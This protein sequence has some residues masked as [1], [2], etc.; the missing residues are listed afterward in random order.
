MSSI[1][2][3][4]GPS[5]APLLFFT[6]QQG[7]QV[8][9]YYDHQP[10]AETVVLI[11]IGRIETALKYL[12]IAR[13]LKQFNFDVVICEHRGQGFSERLTRNPHIGDVADFNH[14][15]LDLKTL[16]RQLNLGRY[17]RRLLLAHSMGG[18]IGTLYLAQY[19]EDFHA[20]ALTAPMF[21]I[22]FPYHLP[23]TLVY[24]LAA[25]LARRDRKRQQVN[26]APTQGDP[27]WA[28]FAANNLTH[29]ETRY[30]QLL[31]LYQTYPQIALGGVSN[32]WLA[33]SL[34]ACHQIKRLP[35][36][37]TPTLL[38]TPMAD[39]IVSIAAQNRF[40]HNQPN[41]QQHYFADS[42]HELLFERDS[43]REE[44]LDKL[45]N[46]YQLVVEK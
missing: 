4:R 6:G 17:K 24:S 34:K 19:P 43:L 27:Y 23:T 30:Q 2:K 44:A 9:Y 16:Y 40:A 21:G 45:I 7:R 22:R 3:S 25:T 46:F 31:S 42:F 11:S 36:L 8:A 41:C 28:P 1:A 29:S 18:A 32:R 10:Q 37:T 26:Y 35:P 38:L 5:S 33:T 20:A 39:Q 12:E 13:Y 14:Y 15:L